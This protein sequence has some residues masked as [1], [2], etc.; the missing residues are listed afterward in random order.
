MFG[1]R[2]RHE[3]LCDSSD[4]LVRRIA[5]RTH[6]E[7]VR[8]LRSD[9]YWDSWQISPSLNYFGLLMIPCALVWRIV[10][11]VVRAVTNEIARFFRKL[12]NL[13]LSDSDRSSME[14]IHSREV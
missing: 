10:W 6:S 13:T 1:R 4:P 11:I 8:R 2:K 9:A 14:S 7:Y 12:R 5:Q 3:N